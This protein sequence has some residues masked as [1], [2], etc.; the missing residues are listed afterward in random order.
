MG[1]FS[2]KA[3]TVDYEFPEEYTGAACLMRSYQKLSPVYRHIDDESADWSDN[4]HK[5]Y[6]CVS[7]TFL[8]VNTNSIYNKLGGCHDAN[9]GQYNRVSDGDFRNFALKAREELGDIPKL[10]N[11]K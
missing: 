5:V 7:G 10:N 3:S 8:I 4:V 9:N 11:P 2:L 6:R 1:L